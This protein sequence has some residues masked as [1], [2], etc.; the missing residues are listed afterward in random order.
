MSAEVTIHI[1]K[2]LENVLTIPV[3]AVVGGAESGKKRKV[4]V[5]T[6]GGPEERE[7]E[8]GLSNERMA[9]VKS[10]LQAGDQVVVNPKAIVG[11]TA[12]TREDM[13]DPS[14]KGKGGMGK[15]GGGKSK[16]KGGPPAEGGTPGEG[17]GSGGGSG[18]APAAKQ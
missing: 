17:G 12:K 14:A 4:W 5:M 3:Q 6:A 11:N 18:K 10:G 7:V 16:G 8:L 2:T 1:D 9:E 13:P 15:G